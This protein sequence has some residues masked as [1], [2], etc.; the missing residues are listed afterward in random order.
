MTKESQ[1]YPSHQLL[2]PQA[3][4]SGILG[5]AQTQWTFAHVLTGNLLPSHVLGNYKAS[6]NASFYLPNQSEHMEKVTSTTPKI[7]SI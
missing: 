1:F 3:L 5:I 6:G 2:G 7:T 4:H